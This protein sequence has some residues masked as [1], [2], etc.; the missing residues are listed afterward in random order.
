MRGSFELGSH[1][2]ASRARRKVE[3]GHKTSAGCL[4]PEMG[5]KLKEEPPPPF[6]QARVGACPAS[7]VQVA[8]AVENQRLEGAVIEHSRQ[9]LGVPGGGALAFEPDAEEQWLPDR[10]RIGLEIGLGPEADLLPRGDVLERPEGPPPEL[11]AHVHED[12]GWI[13]GPYADERL[14]EGLHEDSVARLQ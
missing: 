1:P 14:V 4:G 10:V 11:L 9:E 8:V 13:I 7:V 12:P 5:T 3:V 6:L 2:S